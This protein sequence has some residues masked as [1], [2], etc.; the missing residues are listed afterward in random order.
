MN[1]LCIFHANCADGYTAA[2][3]VNQAQSDVEFFPGFYNTSP[4]NVDGKIVYIVDFS[5]KRSNMESIVSKAKKVIHIDHHDIA[6]KDMAGFSASNFESLYSPEN[7]ESGAMLTWR[8]FYPNIDIPRFIRYIDDRDRWQFKLPS[9]REV[10][11]NV[12]SYDYSFENWNML[13]SQDLEEQI[14]DGTAI[15]RRMAKDVK[16]LLNV[17]VRRM[18]IAG[19]N[20]PIAN[21]PYQFGSDIGHALGKNEPFAG[22]YYDTPTSRIFGLRSNEGGL[23]VGEIAKTFGGGGHEHAAGFKRTYEQARTFE[24]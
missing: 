9:S 10:S 11:A 1:K 16:E 21:V 5:Y 3:V 24:V 6:I 15:E 17:V 12:F 13:M 14:K 19:H 18:N 8:Y 7:T 20:V 4:P 2:W 23:H 22:Y